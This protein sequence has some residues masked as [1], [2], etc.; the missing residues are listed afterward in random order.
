[1]LGGVTPKEVAQAIDCELA[2]A[3]P[4]WKAAKKAKLVDG[5]LVAVADLTLQ[6]DE[7]ATLTPSF[8]H[9][10]IASA[11][12][13]RLFSWG[14][15]LDNQSNR[16][17]NETIVYDLDPDKDARPC[18]VSD[19]ARYPIA[20]DLGLAEVLKRG[21]DTDTTHS[22]LPHSDKA[23]K[24]KTVFGQTVNFVLT[25]N[26]GNIGPT[27]TLTHFKGPGPMFLA[28]RTDTH[29]VIISFVDYAKEEEKPPQKTRSEY[30]LE[31]ICN[32]LTNADCAKEAQK[33]AQAKVQPRFLA[34]KDKVRALGS[35]TTATAGADS[36]FRNAV[37]AAKENNAILRLQGL[38]NILGPSP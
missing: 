31:H 2:S 34:L 28:Q 24:S 36:G 12:F 3:L 16:T 14:M 10:A 37:N 20:S 17:Y 7:Q 27:W 22:D 1:V 33:D 15:K 26:I 25:M 19:T 35:A 11:T 4:I 30:Y 38:S 5:H 6:V 9:T 8:T 18:K 13:S 21:L 32:V 23:D 29:K